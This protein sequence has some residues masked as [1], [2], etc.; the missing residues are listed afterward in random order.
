[1]TRLDIHGSDRGLYGMLLRLGDV[2]DEDR[3]SSTRKSFTPQD[4]AMIKLKMPTG[5]SMVTTT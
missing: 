5:T 1:M 4:P 2:I 3:L